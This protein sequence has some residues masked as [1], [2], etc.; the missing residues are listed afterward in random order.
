MFKRYH[1]DDVFVAG[2]QPTV[3]YVHR[4]EE[5]IERSFA[6][7][8]AT[9]NQ[10]V[11]LSGPTKTGK[12]VLC[13]RTLGERQF[14]WIDGGKVESAQD[15][16]NK[17]AGEL[18]IPHETEDTSHRE[19]SVGVEG[20]VPL[21]TT[22][23][24]SRL[25]G[26]STTHRRTVD[27]MS[28]AITTLLSERIM[29]VIDDFHYIEDSVRPIIMRNVKG[30]VFNG[31]KVILLSV[32]HRV[33]DA[34]K[35]ESELTGRFTAISLPNW[36]DA[37]L[38][39]IP[40]KGFA[41]LRVKYAPEMVLRLCNEAQDNPF[42]MQKFCWEMCFDLG[43]E[44]T[45]LVGSTSIPADY[46]LD[47]MFR[48]ISTDAGLPIYQKLAAG[49]QS[50]KIRAKRPLRDGSTADIYQVI[51]LGL[52]GTGP[53]AV[54]PYDELRSELNAILADQVPQKHEITS[55]LKHL[56]KL[57]REFGTESAI[58]WDDDKREINLVDPYLRFYL[59]WQIRK[60]NLPPA[61]QI[62]PATPPTQMDLGY[63]QTGT[64]RTTA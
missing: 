42:L 25:H 21:I 35:A 33:F 27:S 6:R 61:L 44:E 43:I 29:L 26:S 8:V 63:D 53:K 58:D 28:S 2:G 3:T 9:P 52:A 11:S 64:P 59:R 17:V 16:W 15:F 24:G 39:K 5:H 32:T 45:P 57:S 38:Q 48:R 40:E 30:A 10:I 46:N 12:T 14:V 36:S 51:L 19:T 13:K 20:S 18:N 1:R 22:A 55:A 50:R 23:S 34:I 49:P 41:A 54:V 7:A 31:L 56:A 60:G 62:P 4:E 37:D 47:A